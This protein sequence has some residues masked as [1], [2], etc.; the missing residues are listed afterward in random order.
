MLMSKT[1]FE[2]LQFADVQLAWSLI[3]NEVL[4]RFTGIGDEDK[5]QTTN[6]YNAVKFI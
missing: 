4:K 5:I 6:T 3:G 1:V 2:K